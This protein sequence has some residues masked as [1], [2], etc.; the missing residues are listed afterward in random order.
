MP[1]RR[2]R[3]A[4]VNGPYV[5][6]QRYRVYLFDGTGRQRVATFESAAE[7]EDFAEAARLTAPPSG[8]PTI[9][10]ALEA[11]E[12]FMRRTKE[13]KPS[14]VQATMA[15]LRGFIPRRERE[16]ARFPTASEM[17][18][19]YEAR[20]EKVST[21]THRNEL[22]ETRTFFN[23]CVKRR[24]RRDNPTAEIE[25][26]GK[27]SKGK[28]QL[29]ID[30]ARKMYREL[31]PKVSDDDAALATVMLLTMGLRQSEVTRRV[32]RDVDDDGHVLW[33]P[34][35]KTE[36]GKRHLEIPEVLHT[37]LLRRSLGRAESELLFPG[38]QGRPHR[39]EWLNRNVKRLCRDLG[40]PEV[41]AHGLRGTCS[42]IARAAGQTAHAVAAQLGHAD[43][44]VTREHYEAPGTEQRSMMRSALRV[45]EGGS[46]AAPKGATLAERTLVT[47]SD[48][49]NVTNDG[50]A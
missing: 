15:R 22:A 18:E 11:Y 14:S 49:G 10:D 42:T 50:R 41:T 37:A 31:L 21:D 33:I 4:R 26:Q 6:G 40:L 1:R 38:K 46:S 29:K 24:Y 3:Q 36:A 12:G 8:A 25:G 2:I 30:E 28:A 16:V 7:A 39:K 19:R 32:V 5:H 27:R 45:I 17:L 48:P 20:T 13:N 9:E 23:F 35:A 43:P 47:E 44:R 34:D